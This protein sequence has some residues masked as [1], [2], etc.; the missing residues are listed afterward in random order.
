MA[1][2]NA[3]EINRHFWQSF[4]TSILLSIIGAGVDNV[5]VSSSDNYNASQAYRV[6]TA[7]SLSQTANQSLRQTGVSSP[8]LIVNQGKPIM[9]FVAHDLN[10][11]EAMKQSVK[12]RLDVF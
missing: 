2:F 8:T 3:D 1:G 5:D 7:D 4:G 10:F 6:A 9:I 11:S 12:N